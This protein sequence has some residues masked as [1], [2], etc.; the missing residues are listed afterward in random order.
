MKAI[1]TTIIA[2]LLLTNHHLLKAQT[3]QSKYPKLSANIFT[4]VDNTTNALK[5]MLVYDVITTGAITSSP[6]FGAPLGIY[7][8]LGSFNNITYNLNNTTTGSIPQQLNYNSRI[9]NGNIIYLAHRGL[10]HIEAQVWSHGLSSPQ[11]WFND[12]LSPKWFAYTILDT[13]LVSVSNNPM[14]TVFL[15]D[16]IAAKRMYSQLKVKNIPAGLHW[17]YGPD[18]LKYMWNY[19]CFKDNDSSA[20]RGCFEIMAVKRIDTITGEVTVARKWENG[21][22]AGRTI[23]GAPQSYST[24]DRAGFIPHSSK[25]FGSPAFLMNLYSDTTDAKYEIEMKANG[26]DWIGACREYVESILMKSAVG[27]TYLCDGVILDA[28]DEIWNPYGFHLGDPTDQTYGYKLDLNWDGQIDMLDSVNA[29]LP[30][31]YNEFSQRIHDVAINMGRD[32]YTIINGHIVRFPTQL[33]GRLFEDFNGGFNE[34]FPAAVKQYLSLQDTNNI[35][36]PGISTV[37]ERDRDSAKVGLINFKEHRH[38]MAL[39]TV[40]GEGFYGHIGAHATHIEAWGDWGDPGPWQP[41][42]P[43]PEDWVDEFSVDITTGKSAKFMNS[44]STERLKYSRWLGGAINKGIKIDSSYFASGWAYTFQRD[45]DN[46]IV[47]YSQYPHT[48]QLDTLY[49]MIDGADP[50]NTGDTI[51]SVTFSTSKMGI[52]LIRITPFSTNINTESNNNQFKIYPNPANN[53][54]KLD[55]GSN[56]NRSIIVSD[57]VGKNIIKFENNS[58]Y[59]EINTSYFANGI[60]FISVIKDNK[61]IT[62]KIIINH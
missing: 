28:D 49:K 14:D 18:S 31:T 22:A 30:R 54:I 21:S 39:T 11:R 57:I 62:H 33:S 59:T 35:N 47:I 17:G 42:Q 1:F 3:I 27:S 36:I 12:R 19:I 46:G 61:R 41:G 16:T 25:G 4:D 45:F 51:N 50:G 60:Y 24:G 5:E 9:A 7:S 26:V 37:Y 29:W 23:Y 40:L 56:D 43:D 34:S 13:L 52:F 38:I 44:N 32:F 53:V 48:I 6:P 58:N 55:F 8:G 20:N 10:R 2:L 15:F